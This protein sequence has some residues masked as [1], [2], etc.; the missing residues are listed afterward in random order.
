MIQSS[1]E[2]AP[3]GAANFWQTLWH[4]ILH[5][6]RKHANMDIQD[7]EKVVEMFARGIYQVLQDNGGRLFDLKETDGLV[8]RPT[9]TQMGGADND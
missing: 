3:K 6:I 2:E 5:S 1:E 8:R 4:E 9:P 7:E